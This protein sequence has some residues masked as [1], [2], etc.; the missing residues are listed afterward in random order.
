MASQALSF[1]EKPLT[2]LYQLTSDTKRLSHVATTVTAAN[3]L[4]E[5]YNGNMATSALSLLC[6]SFFQII[7]VASQTTTRNISVGKSQNAE[8][9]CKLAIVPLVGLGLSYLYHWN[10]VFSI[11][12]FVGAAF[13]HNVGNVLNN[14]DIRKI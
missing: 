13:V 14:R 11:L 3:G 4:R 7:S 8:V 6:A 9:F 2:Y 10:V 1:A 12:T 5:F